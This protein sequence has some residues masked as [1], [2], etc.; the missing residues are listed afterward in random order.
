MGGGLLSGPPAAA[1][2]AAAVDSRLAAMALTLA[3]EVGT[4]AAPNLRA[5]GSM[6][7]SARPLGNSGS[8]GRALPGGNT[9]KG[10]IF[11]VVVKNFVKREQN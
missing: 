8:L 9:G 11:K 2:A 7:A 5:G 4:A 6:E 1:A 10:T 3:R